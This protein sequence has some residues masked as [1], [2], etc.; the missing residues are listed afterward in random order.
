M[1][2]FKSTN[3]YSDENVYQCHLTHADQLYLDGC[4]VL[5]IWFYTICIELQS[6]MK[7]CYLKRAACYLKVF[8]V[9][10]CELILSCVYVNVFFLY[11]SHKKRSM[12]V[13]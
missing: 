8:E 2:Y 11:R 9:G 3:E 1:N 10:S 4:Y 7:E 13:K 6:D 5:A 12:I